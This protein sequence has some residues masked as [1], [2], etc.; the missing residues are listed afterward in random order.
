MN[1]KIYIFLLFVLGIFIFV[2]CDKEE[3]EVDEGICSELWIE[4]VE[5]EWNAVMTAAQEYGANQTVEN[6]LAYKAA[7]QAYVD[8]LEPFGKCTQWSG[9]T[10]AEWETALAEAQESVDSIDCEE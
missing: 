8:A 1:R 2:S 3:D 10:R 9:A 7:A 6:C 5:D 4:A